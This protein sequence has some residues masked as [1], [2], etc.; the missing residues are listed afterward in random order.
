M[1]ELKM[2]KA[3]FKPLMTAVTLTVRQSVDPIAIPSRSLLFIYF[4]FFYFVTLFTSKAEIEPRFDESSSL[5]ERVTESAGEDARH[6]E[7]PVAGSPTD[8]FLTTR[9]AAPQC[10]T[11]LPEG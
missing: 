8:R 6:G 3:F 9:L 7:N 10:A 2:Q 5:T 4:Y 11:L 1:H